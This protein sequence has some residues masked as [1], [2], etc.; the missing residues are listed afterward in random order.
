MT[1]ITGMWVLPPVLPTDSLSVHHPL[2][3]AVVS[4]F[5]CEGIGL[6][7]RQGPSV[8]LKDEVNGRR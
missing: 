5:K 2:Y 1:G 6:G 7:P 4:S 3:L 8:S